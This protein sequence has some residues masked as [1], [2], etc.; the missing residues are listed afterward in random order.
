METFYYILQKHMN[1]NVIISPSDGLFEYWHHI[2][3]N[4]RETITNENRFTNM[5]FYWF[6]SECY[7]EIKKLDYEPVEFSDVVKIK[8]ENL[9]N[10][11]D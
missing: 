9:L 1:A 6:I 3:N 10:S 4:E 8:F 11:F 7:N 2:F 5:H